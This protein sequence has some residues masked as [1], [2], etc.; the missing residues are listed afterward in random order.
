[1]D[2]WEMSR[3][4]GCGKATSSAVPTIV[5]ADNTTAMAN[6]CFRSLRA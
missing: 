2:E 6:K 1:M 5:I 4:Q 3:A